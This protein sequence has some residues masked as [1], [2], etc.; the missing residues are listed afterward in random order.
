MVT[1]QLIGKG[2]N[3]RIVENHPQLGSVLVASVRGDVP[4][5]MVRAQKLVDM[6]NGQG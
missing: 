2:T 3:Y 4:E 6:A 1:Y 5:D